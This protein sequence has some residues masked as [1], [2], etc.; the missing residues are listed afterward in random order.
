MRDGRDCGARL[1]RSSGISKRRGRRKEAT[2]ASA[3]AVSIPVRR[4]SP[5]F[6]SEVAAASVDPEALLAAV[7]DA[8]PAEKLT[9]VDHAIRHQ[10][11]HVAAAFPEER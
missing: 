2:G 9:L 8:T 5:R 10:A 1:A 3:R 7:S 6:A 4:A 11:P